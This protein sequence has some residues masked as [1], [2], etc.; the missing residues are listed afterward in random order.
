M[1]AG[2][3][4]G[5]GSAL[6]PFGALLSAASVGVV[7]LILPSNRRS[8]RALA[9]ALAVLAF[10]GGWS[11]GRREATTAFNECVARAESVRDALRRHHDSTGAFPSELSNLRSPVVG[12][13]VVRGTIWSYEQTPDGYDLELSDALVTHRAT[14][15]HPLTAHK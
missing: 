6:L 15:A 7:G 2:V 5:E 10:G 13:L 9:A 11:V 4:W 8:G 3:W 1:V 12:R 14:H